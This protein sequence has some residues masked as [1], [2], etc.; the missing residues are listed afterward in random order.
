MVMETVTGM[1]VF[2]RV[3]ETGSMAAAAQQLGMAP[4]DVAAAIESLESRLGT[5]LFKRSARRLRPTPIGRAFYERSARLLS[6]AR[7]IEESLADR[8]EPVTAPLRILLPVDLGCRYLGARIADLLHDHPQLRLTAEFGDGAVAG[9][10]AQYDLAICVDSVP[11]EGYVTERIATVPQVVC[12]S[13]AYLATRARPHHPLELAQM[14]CLT[15]PGRPSAAAWEFEG[16]GG[17]FPVGVHG[18]LCSQDTD[19]LKA[20]VLDGRGAALLPVYACWQELA[21]N[22]LERVLADYRAA[23]LAVH[24]AYLPSKR[25]HPG[26][27]LLT[28]LVRDALGPGAPWR[29]QADVEP[30]RTAAPVAR[31]GELATVP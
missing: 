20:A 23:S 25:R 14:S 31:Q 26:I 7:E 21:D 18:A 11:G 6:E 10:A 30:V 8:R 5:T 2:V 4:D 3:A 12:A 17:R 13:P 19:L 24:A 28:D 27:R 29:D 22:R 9:V 1:V 16:R 15:M